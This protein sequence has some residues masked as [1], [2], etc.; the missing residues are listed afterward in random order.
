[1]WLEL[2]GS[3]AAFLAHAVWYA[4]RAKRSLWRHPSRPLL[5]GLSLALVVASFAC[6]IGEH[7]A[8]LGAC[9]AFAALST[10]AS[11]NVLVAPVRPF[12]FYATATAS[13]AALGVGLLGWVVNVS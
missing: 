13:L 1:V 2:A 12:A 7:G 9:V 5:P 3:G 10:A 4:G 8:A 11:V 6:W